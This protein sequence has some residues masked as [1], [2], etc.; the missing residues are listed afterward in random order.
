MS[1]TTTR[2]V[3]IA[4]GALLLVACATTTRGYLLVTPLR[5]PIDEVYSVE[6]QIS[7]TSFTTERIDAWTV[8]GFT[9]QA[10]RFYKGIANGEPIVT[11][12]K[13]E[14]RRPRF[15]PTM[16]ETEI[17][18]LVVDSLYNGRARPGELR[19]V[20]FGSAPGFRFDLNYVTN[21]GVNRRALVIGAVIKEKLELI[22]Y[23]GTALH[24]FPRHQDAV[25]RVIQS[26]Q[27]R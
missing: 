26:I 12:G 6:P 15:R 27:L 13:D 20:P 7:W 19:P 2:A 5:V 8:D 9:L 14:E 18:E 3:A 23:D 1:A 25:E 24:Y 17:A 21:E 4:L 16:A 11:G 10:L 22:I